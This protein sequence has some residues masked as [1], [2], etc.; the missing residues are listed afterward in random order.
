MI[1]V[2]WEDARAY[3]KWLSQKTGRNFRL[4][5][6]AEWEYAA[7][8]GTRAPYFWEGLPGTACDF[9]NGFDRAHEQELKARFSIDWA[10]LP[11]D[12]PY[13]TLAPV[14]SFGYNSWHL[15]DLAGNVWEWVADCYHDS[16]AGAP[17]GPAAWTDGMECASGRRVIRGG[18]WGSDPAFL[19]SANRNGYT[20][21]NRYYNLGFR[22]AQDIK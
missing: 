18:S 12:D 3:A 19:R 1:N 16:Y 7:R 5:T 21:D 9:A 14:G 2:S 6:E 11:C 4:P 15:H 17:P 13:A 22:L 20:P 10:P 8:A